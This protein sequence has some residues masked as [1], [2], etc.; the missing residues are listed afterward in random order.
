[1]LKHKRTLICINV[2]LS[3][4]VSGFVDKQQQKYL[5]DSK[6]PSSASS[7]V[8]IPPENYDI[9]FNVSSPIS[10]VTYSGI[11]FEKT[12]QGWVVNGYDD[13]N[14]YF[15][16]FETF[17]QQKDP[18]ISVAG[19]SEPFATWEQE[20]RFNN[21]G[22]I[23]YRGTFYRAT[24]TFTSGET[25]DKSN[26]VQLPDLPVANAVTAQQRRNFNSF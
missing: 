3:S 18:V 8:F 24:A 5:L 17:P 25:F 14:P 16:T 2:R 19:T 7:S 9:I 12:T 26:L 11:I 13:I 20:K 22:I 10:S 15:N 4:R 23:Q 1:M 6:N 21:G